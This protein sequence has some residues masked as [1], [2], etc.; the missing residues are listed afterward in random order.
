LGLITFNDNPGTYTYNALRITD[1]A[2][3][4]SSVATISVTVMNPVGSQAPVA[5]AKFI[6]NGGLPSSSIT[7]T[8]GVPVTI[9][10]DASASSD[11]DGWTT[12]GTGVSQ[13]GK[14]EWNTNLDQSKPASFKQTI[15][16][17]TTPAACNISL[18][19]LTFN[20]A[21]GTYSYTLLRITD[22]S[23]SRSI[24]SYSN[25]ANTGLF[26]RLFSSIPAANAAFAEQ[27]VSVTVVE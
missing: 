17:P 20:D 1:A 14:C 16:N 27:S 26:A 23:G 9:D 12:P 24:A 11:P 2:G 5:V 21:P 10:L 18:G 6:V 19:T 7:V 3:A 25:P 13:G 4:V 15:L 22:A 8:R